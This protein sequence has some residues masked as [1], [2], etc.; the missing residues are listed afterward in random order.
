MINETFLEYQN[1]LGWFNGYYREHEEK[2]RRLIYL[3]MTTDDNRDPAQLLLELYHQAEVNRKRIQEL[4]KSIK[5][6]M[7]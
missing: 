6:G 3:K 5:G 1:L 2:Y 4:E 7:Q